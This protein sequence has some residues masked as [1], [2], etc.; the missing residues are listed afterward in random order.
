MYE[1]D[2]GGVRYRLDPAA[3]SA[4]RYRAIFG[5]SILETLNRG[6]PPKKL[7]GKLLRMCHLMIPAADRPELLVLARQARRDG[8]FLV[9]SQ[10]A[11]RTVGTGHRAGWAAGRGELRRTV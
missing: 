9:G 11:G 3:I 8:A 6:I 4:L 2:L 10:S 5:E 7:E 1:M